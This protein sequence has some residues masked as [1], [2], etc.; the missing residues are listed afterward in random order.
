LGL[1][2]FHHWWPLYLYCLMYRNMVCLRVRFG[3]LL[4]GFNSPAVRILLTSVFLRCTSLLFHTVL[5]THLFVSLV[6][7]STVSIF[8]FAPSLLFLILPCALSC[9]CLGSSWAPCHW[10][11]LLSQVRLRSFNAAFPR[12][13]CLSYF[14]FSS[15]D[16]SWRT[17]EWETLWWTVHKTLWE[18]VALT[19]VF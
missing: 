5:V 10:F 1:L 17:E 3:A 15:V 18:E 16:Y 14:L 13:S 6:F 8:P 7:S 11:L 9:F 19:L 12:W 2:L 4:T